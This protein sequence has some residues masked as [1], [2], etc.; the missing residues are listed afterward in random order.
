MTLKA[1]TK[2]GSALEEV[3]EMPK[4]TFVASEAE[5]LQRDW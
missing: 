5:G 3:M 1:V 4:R 2:E